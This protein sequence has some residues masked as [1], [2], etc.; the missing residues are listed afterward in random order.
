[1]PEN[2]YIVGGRS[3]GK[4]RAEF[5]PKRI[6]VAGLSQGGWIGPL[7]ASISADVAFVITESAAGMDAHEQHLFVQEN[8]LRKNG[9]AESA[10]KKIIALHA[11]LSTF[12]RTGEGK[13]AL[14]S[15]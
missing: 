11:Q 13:A 9:V 1:M 8:I 10:V 6:G 12:N 2:M 14:E 15:R 5:D 3:Q 7:A 4:S